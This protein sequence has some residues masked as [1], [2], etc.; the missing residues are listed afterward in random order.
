[1]SVP[2]SA[3][4]LRAA[5][6]ILQVAHATI[7]YI[8]PDGTGDLPT[9]QAAVDSCADGDEIVLVDGEFSG[10]GN[11]AV[12]FRGK[13]V[14]LR[15][16]SGNPAACVLL[17]DYGNCGELLFTSGE[18]PDTV[19]QDIT[20]NSWLAWCHPS[21]GA[22]HCAGSSPTIRNVAIN[23]CDRG[24]TVVSG[25]SPRFEGV[26]IFASRL[27]AAD[28]SSASPT[29]QGCVIEGNTSVGSAGWGPS[30]GILMHSS[31]AALDSCI[32]RNNG[33]ISVNLSGSS[34]VLTGCLIV[35]NAAF[36][37]GALLASLGSH[38]VVH[39]CTNSGNVGP[40]GGIS[41][42]VTSSVDLQN[43]IVWGNCGFEYGE[44]TNAGGVL[45]ASC[46]DLR[47]DGIGG[48]GSMSMT[49]VQ[50]LDPLFCAPRDC[51]LDWVAGEYAVD[52]QS[53]LVHGSCGVVGFSV[54][55]CRV[56]VEPTSWGRL[57]AL[58]R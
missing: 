42:D 22:I 53:P 39:R 28:I 50:D 49:E 36:Y 33:P 7:Y 48:G 4:L 26:R 25:A 30:G 14:T 24:I 8:T 16:Q 57:K 18:G 21:T 31:N 23:A 2:R 34:P 38:P 6:G 19:V 40:S 15:S 43:S 44:I 29:L 37:G 51:G 35:N 55:N 32:V 41:I 45:T 20:L 47:L 56:S 12:N 5:S 13:A 27:V 1:M 10:N 58:Y 11:L 46:S 3:L 54:A 9:I 52:D 17:G